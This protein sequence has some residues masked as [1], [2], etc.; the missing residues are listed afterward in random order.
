MESKAKRIVAVLAVVAVTLATAST[1][2]A[3]NDGDSGD[4]NEPGQ[5]TESD[6]PGADYSPQPR[7]RGP[8]MGSYCHTAQGAC[9]MSYQLPVGQSCY[10]P[11]YNGSAYGEVR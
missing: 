9:P 11:T 1:A 5:S 8:E 10:C 2:V 7:D 4:F 6:R 3:W